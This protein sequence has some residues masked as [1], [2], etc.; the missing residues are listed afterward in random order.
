MIE[1]LLAKPGD[2]VLFVAELLVLLR[3]KILECLDHLSS[4]FSHLLRLLFSYS[5]NLDASVL[6]GFLHLLA[7]TLQV[8][9]SELPV[10]EARDNCVLRADLI[11]SLV[12]L[13]LKLLDLRLKEFIVTLS[14][15]IVANLDCKVSGLI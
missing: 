1:H 7:I 11:Y 10:F 4:S 13:S 6:N 14:V 8:L 9:V 15:A 2:H 3:K 12:Q 5:I